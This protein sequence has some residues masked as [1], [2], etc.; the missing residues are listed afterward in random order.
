VAPPQVAEPVQPEQL[1]VVPLQ[2]ASV[3]ASGQ[4]LR[5]SKIWLEHL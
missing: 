3:Q 1:Q 4:T 5:Q 2:A